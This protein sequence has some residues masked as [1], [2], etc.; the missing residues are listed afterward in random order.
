[1]IRLP[2]PEGRLKFRWERERVREKEKEKERHEAKQG[3]RTQATLARRNGR[4]G[5]GGE[6]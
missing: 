1:M 5:S 6:W 4:K 2:L 3:R